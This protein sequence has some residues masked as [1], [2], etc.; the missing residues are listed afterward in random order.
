MM[1]SRL[2]KL[3]PE[4]RGK[5]VLIFGDVMLDEHI[6]SK[7]SRISP[8]APVVVA[9][10]QKISHVPGGCGNVAANVKALGGVPY[11]VG[12]VGYD[13]SADKLLAAL[14]SMG[15]PTNFII[16][17]KQR[18]TILK[19]RIIAGSQHVVRVDREEKNQF[20]KALAQKILK[21][22][23]R[24]IPKVDAVIIS[25][26]AKGMTEKQ[27]CQAIIKAANRHKKPILIDPKGTDYS[28]YKGATIITPNLSEA[29]A[30]SGLK[31]KDDRNLA[32]AGKSLLK[33]VGSPCV[34]ITRG[35]NGM[36]LFEKNGLIHDIAGVPREVFDITG[37]GDT[38]IS[39]LALALAAN[40]KP[41]EACQLANLAGSVKV[42]KIATQPVYAY[43][44]KDALEER[45]PASKKIKTREELKEIVERLKRENAKIVFTNGCFD[46]LH[47][48]H[49]RYLKE[50]KKLGDVLIVG[51]NSDSSVRKLKGATRP[52][53][54]EHERAE[55]MAS[56]ESVDYVTIFTETLPDNLIKLVRPNVH[57][58]GGDYKISQLPERKLVQELG[59]KVVVIPP[60][61]GKSTTSLIDKIL[62]RHK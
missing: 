31:I 11:L 43:E 14:K 10:V 23:L 37:A 39:T 18:P 41:P 12:T 3:I 32:S 17:D 29:E 55:I 44:L 20:P 40:A 19:S 52:Y 1:E 21:H 54:S 33:T 61:E 30:A 47:L 36:A 60:V 34:L 25:D 53:I 2:K 51:L 27:T 46:I 22:T 62:G 26:Y 28:K 57:V 4:F 16:Q 6:W 45:E 24:Q 59:G 35:E 42:T 9:D 49:I 38:V 7:V 8:E 56:L 15:I 13:S 58:K 48:G 50:A 5:K